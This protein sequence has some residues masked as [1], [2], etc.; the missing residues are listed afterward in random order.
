MAMLMA[1]C[2]LMYTCSNQCCYQNPRANASCVHLRLKMHAAKGT[3]A[4]ALGKARSTH[5]VMVSA[6]TH[7]TQMCVINLLGS[8]DV[9]KHNSALK[10]STGQ[11][12]IASAASKGVVGLLADTRSA[13]R[14][15]VECAAQ[16][17]AGECAGGDQG[18]HHC[19][20]PQFPHRGQPVWPHCRVPH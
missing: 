4:P 15:C 11:L 20:P 16:S 3:I 8:P 13:S 14:Q 1:T 18:T 19:H 10:L 12:A 17:G 9:A 2:L 5:C 6:W 7:I